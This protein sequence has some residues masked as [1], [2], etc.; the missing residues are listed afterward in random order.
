ML[1]NLGDFAYKRAAVG[2][3]NAFDGQFIEFA[4]H[5]FVGF[6]E[7]M[8]T[9]TVRAAKIDY[10]RVFFLEI[11]AFSMQELHIQILHLVH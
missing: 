1:V 9:F 8:S 6:G 11:Y 10:F 3:K 2:A 4:L 7:S 5:E